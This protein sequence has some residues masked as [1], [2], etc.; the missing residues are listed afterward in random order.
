M[1]NK[2]LLGQLKRCPLCQ[3]SF[4]LCQSCDRG[5][6]YC[7]RACRNTARQHSLARAARRYRSSHMGRRAH[8]L[9]QKRYRRNKRLKE[10]SE[11]HHS[12]AISPSSLGQERARM[13]EG[14]HGKAH[15]RTTKTTSAICHLCRRPITALLS[16]R[17]YPRRRQRIN[18]K[19]ESIHDHSGNTS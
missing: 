14:T 11:I 18:I 16:A 12:P 10:K 6:W 4:H 15:T 1:E 5:H 8:S 17:H 3:T 19:E 9:A 2:V 13:E 7:S